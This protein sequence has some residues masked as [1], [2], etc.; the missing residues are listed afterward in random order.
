V[1]QNPNPVIVQNPNSVMAQNPNP[2]VVTTTNTDNSNN[3]D[4]AISDTI[5]LTINISERSDKKNINIVINI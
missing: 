1:A 2:V 3:Y 5:K 4:V